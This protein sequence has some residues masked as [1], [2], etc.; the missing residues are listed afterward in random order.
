MNPALT[1]LFG[2]VKSEAA[3]PENVDLLKNGSGF[4]FGAS[5]DIDCGPDKFIYADVKLKGGTDALIVRRDSFMC[6]GSDFR[7]SGR[8]YVYLALGAGISF[9]DKHHEFLD[10][11]AGASLQAEF[12]KPYHIAGEFGFRFRLLH[13]LIKGDADAWFDAGESCKWERVLFPPS[14]SAATKKN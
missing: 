13:G 3:N 6:G 14:D 10:I 8:T 12:P 7:G 1:S 11:Q 2:V 4:A 5:V 9:R